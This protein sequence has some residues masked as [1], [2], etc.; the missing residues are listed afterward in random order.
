MG[1]IN[2]PSLP[3]EF[4]FHEISML[5]VAQRNVTP[6]VIENGQRPKKLRKMRTAATRS[7]IIGRNEW[8]VRILRNTF[9]VIGKNSY[10]SNALAD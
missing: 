7:H 2:L 4:M 10:L 9:H 5:V 6:R 8:R 1:K 3:I